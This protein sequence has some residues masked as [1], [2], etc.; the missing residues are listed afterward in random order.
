MQSTDQHDAEPV[1]QQAVP[2]RQVIFEQTFNQLMNGFGQQCEELKISCA[3][4]IAKHP[5]HDEPMVFYRGEHIL[6]AATLM[7]DVLRQIKREILSDLDID[8]AKN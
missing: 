7:A 3:I 4:A 5:D 8:A 2:D 1:L 6:D